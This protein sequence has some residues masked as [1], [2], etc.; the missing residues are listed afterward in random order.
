MMPWRLLKEEE[1]QGSIEY[2]LIVG[3]A[4]IAAIVILVVYMSM[5]KSGGASINQPTNESVGKLTTRM[6]EAANT[7]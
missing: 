1:G 2:I 3:G 7:I 4:V 6:Q 5:S